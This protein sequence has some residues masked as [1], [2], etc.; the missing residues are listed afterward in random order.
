M[1][2]GMFWVFRKVE[3]KKKKKLEETLKN[4]ELKLSIFHNL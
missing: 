1:P 3:L 2:V 4:E